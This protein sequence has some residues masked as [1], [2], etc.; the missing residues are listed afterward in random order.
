M[1]KKTSL[2]LAEKDYEKL[3]S[4]GQLYNRAVS[5][6]ILD[7][8][9]AISMESHNIETIRKESRVPVDLN[10]AIHSL[11]YAEKTG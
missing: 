3:S 9:D 4:L 11:L 10:S 6:V 1:T 7:I 8:I 2:D 5:Q